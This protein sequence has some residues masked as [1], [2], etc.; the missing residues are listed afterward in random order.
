[1]EYKAFASFT[2]Q[3]EDRTVEG[4]SAVTGNIDS[5]RDR[6]VR[7]AFK[8]TLSEGNRAVHLWMHD[9]M[10]PPTAAI[11]SIKEVGKRDLPNELKERFPD[12]TGGLLVKRTYLETPRGDEIL[13]GIR[14][15]AI[16]EMSIGY[17]AMDFDFE[18]VNKQLV[19]NLKQVR[20]WDTSDVTWGMNAATVASK[21]A[22]PYMD[23]KAESKDV[24]WIGAPTLADFTPD[25]WED[26]SE[27]EQ[28]RIALHF[29]YGSEQPDS[30][31]E[32]K[33]CHHMPSTDGV[34]KIN[35]HGV[36]Q[37]LDGL[38]YTDLPEA[39]KKAVYDH[40]SQHI[41]EYEEKAAP[42]ALFELASSVRKTHRHL[43]MPEDVVIDANTQELKALLDEIIKS[44][45]QAGP[46]NA[47]T[48]EIYKYRIELME[49]ED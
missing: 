25:E 35:Y 10:T 27:A 13:T 43:I 12:A 21:W 4:L 33:Y 31:E 42:Y 15:D 48:G 49:F 32:L 20:L 26:L 30:F 47:P 1:M 3:I 39:E 38:L 14:A 7:G 17:D 2:K 19:R 23:T 29:A 41:E 16:K 28:K 45:A 37:A 11:E 46:Q 8:K 36:K 5:G 22:I 9:M 18:E 34:G 24:E 6:I 40:L 44:L